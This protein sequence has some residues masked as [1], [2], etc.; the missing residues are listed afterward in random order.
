MNKRGQ[1]FLLAAIVIIGVVYGLSSIY[2]SVETP[3]EYPF[4]YDLTKEIKYEGNTV[5]D[6]GLFNSETEE[7]IDANIQN[8]TD[9]YGSAN[10]GSDL[11]ILYGNS[12]NMTALFYATTDTG[13]IG[14]DLGTGPGFSHGN[15]QIRKYSNTF[16]VPAGDESVTIVL[17]E[18]EQEE[19]KHTFNVKPGEMFF[20]VLKK[21]DQ[22]E[23]F[24]AA[25]KEQ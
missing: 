20:I 16:E 19:I 4:I 23:Q 25:S 17:D 22:G 12:S 24:V 14:I 6:S 18:N 8:L 21:E 7:K 2:T 3:D 1:F 11:I 13:S 5:I 10:L 9:Y 15:T